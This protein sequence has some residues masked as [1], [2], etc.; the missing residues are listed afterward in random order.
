MNNKHGGVMVNPHMGQ[1]KMW[2]SLSAHIVLGLFLFIFQM[3]SVRADELALSS[4][5]FASQSGDKL[6]IEMEMTGAAIA[7]KIF[8]TDNPARIALDFPG[9]KSALAKKMYPINQGAASSVYVVE[10]AGMVRVVVNLVE[11]T[12]FETKVVGNK[13]LLT[14]TSAKAA[15]PTAINPE[16]VVAKAAPSVAAPA[17]TK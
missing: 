4:I 17:A 12:P 1:E 11:A 2:L 10:A 9:V 6:Q 3:A 5:D 14:L 16:P 13:V 8:K 15:M 7:P